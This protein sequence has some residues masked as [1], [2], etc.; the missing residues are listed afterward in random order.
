[1][2][3]SIDNV[4]EIVKIPWLY[5]SFFEVLIER[6]R[7]SDGLMVGGPRYKWKRNLLV[8]GKGTN[9]MVYINMEDQ[10]KCLKWLEIFN[11]IHVLKRDKLNT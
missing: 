3:R 7:A 2:I 11:I 10:I 1:M 9:Q 5:E 4:L 8:F 6:W